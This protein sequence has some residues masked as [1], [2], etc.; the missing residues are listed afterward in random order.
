MADDYQYI[1]ATGLIVPDTSDILL[2]VT[3]EFQNAF[4]ANLVVTPD[5]P[6]G[7][8][9]TGET[10]ARTEVVNNNAAVANQINPNI[11]G[12]PFLDAVLALMGIQRSQAVPTFVPGVTLSGASS[13]VIPAGTLAATAAGDQFETVANAV[14]GGGGTVTVDF[15]S[16]ENGPIPCAAHGLNVVVSAILGLETVDNTNAGVPGSDTQSDFQARAARNNLLGFQGV[17]EDVAITSALYNVPGVQSIFYQTNIADTTQTINGISM[18]AH[19]IYACVNGGTDADV[20]AALLE[21][22]TNG[23]N[24]NG[25][26]TVNLVE[27]ASGQTYPVKF[28]RPDAI[29]ISIEVTTSN[30]VDAN[31]KQAILDYIATAWTIGQDV[32]PFELACAIISQYPS[33]FISLVRISYSSSIS[34]TTNTLAIAVHE[35]ATTSSGSI[36]VIIA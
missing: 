20:A 2:A 13:T 6:A 29:G 32:S 36:S 27:P 8:L 1:N 30:G 10:L 19:S 26:V 17:S 9:I 35:I 12:G 28:S 34:W 5:S 14:I 7:V 31:I 22:K 25:A 23:A 4:G 11:A 18:L 3:A 24:W 16:V 15:K 21:N 33:Y